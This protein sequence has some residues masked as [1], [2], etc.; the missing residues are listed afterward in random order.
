MLWIDFS[1]NCS[2]FHKYFLNFK[3]DAIEKQST[4]NF[5]RYR[6]KS[7]ASVVLGVSE[8]TFLKEGDDTAFCSFL[9]CILFI[10]GVA[11][12]KK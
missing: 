3:F 7:H 8:V 2:D 10:Y 5:N 12:S 6:N 11:K 1:G 4:M 9:F